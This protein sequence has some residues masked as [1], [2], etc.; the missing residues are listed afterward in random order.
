M[1]FHEGYGMPIVCKAQT[2]AAQS[3]LQVQASDTPLA[4]NP[5]LRRDAMA[6]AGQCC[7]GD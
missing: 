7:H 2:G 3:W 1:S 6:K 5:V 4:G